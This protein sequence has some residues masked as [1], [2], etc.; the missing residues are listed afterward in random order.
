MSLYPA[1]S[2][3]SLG[4]PSAHGLQERL[5]QAASHGFRG[6]ELFFG[7]LEY[8]ARRHPGGVT[9]LNLQIAAFKARQ[10]CDKFR[11]SVICLQSFEFYEGLLNRNDHDRRIAHA[12]LWFDICH[13]LQTDLILVPSNSLGTDI[14]TGAP[15]TTSNI[16]VIVED[17]QK[18]ADL[19][20]AQSPPIRFAYEALAWGSHINLWEKAW[21]VVQCVNRPNF[22]LCID[23]FHVA[24]R[25]YADPTRRS[26][27][28][29]G[30]KRKL[31]NSL[32]RLEAWIKIDKLFLLQIADGERL[33]S[34]LVDGHP[35]H[36][37]L[38]PPRMSWSRNA[39][40]FPCE[41]ERGG[42]LPVMDIL[43]VFLRKGYLG[44][45]SMEL[46]SWTAIKADFTVP[47]DHA[48]RASESW[49]RMAKEWAQGNKTTV[50]KDFFGSPLLQI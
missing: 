41:P 18:L 36:V 34:P 43:R 22:G 48:G 47:S 9:P 29:P 1:I 2:T 44:W 25:V 31:N 39:R 7:D 10:L 37:P 28:V 13:L 40:L 11:L 30:G 49:R 19:G 23:T 42:Y 20:R 45:A 8:M 17:L 32:V 33:D 3:M 16:T 26:G 38:Q 50:S 21:K 6:I 35:W 24:G 15:K 5:A 4:H 27:T 14:E 12:H 46:F